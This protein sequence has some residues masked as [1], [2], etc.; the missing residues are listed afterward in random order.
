MTVTNWSQKNYFHLTDFEHE[1]N[2]RWF[3]SMASRLK[4]DGRLIVPDLGKAFNKF[5]Q[6]V[7]L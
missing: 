4:D 5:G 3:N 6:E 2:N 7:S 1:V